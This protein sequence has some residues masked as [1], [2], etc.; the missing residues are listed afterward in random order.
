MKFLSQYSLRFSCESQKLL[1]FSSLIMNSANVHNF[2]L[3]SN[4]FKVLMISYQLFQRERINMKFWR[5]INPRYRPSTSF[6]TE[7]GIVNGKYVIGH[8]W[9]IIFEAICI[10]KIFSFFYATL[11]YFDFSSWRRNAPF[12]PSII[13]PSIISRS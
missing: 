4:N 12:S 13:Y 3:S 11:L 10:S 8:T 7:E 1:Y 6:F 2:L 5:G 9:K